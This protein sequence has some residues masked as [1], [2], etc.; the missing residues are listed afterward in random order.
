MKTHYL[1]KWLTAALLALPLPT[2][3]EDIDLFVGIPPSAADAPNVLLVLDNAANF[4]SSAAGSTC[5][6]DGVATLLSGTVGG[7]EQCA[8]YK[9][10]ESLPTTT[11]PDTGADIVL[12]NVGVMAYNS[13]NVVD[14][15]NAPC[16][17]GGVGGC[18]LYPITALTATN[19]A[20]FLAWI[21]TWKTSGGGPGYIKASG[22]ATGAAMQEAWA[23]FSGKTG[24]SGKS[25]AAIK[26]ASTC[27]KN[28]LVFVGN[29]YSSS[30]SPGD[31]APSGNGPANSLT[32]TNP[33]SDKNAN[34]AATTAQKAIITN[35]VNTTCGSFTFPASA[36]E[37]KGFYADEWAR[38]M[39]ASNIVTYTVGILG[40]SCQASYAALLSRMADDDAGGGTYFPTTNYTELVLAF[41]KIFSEIQNKESVFAS[42]SLPVSVNTQGTYLNQVFIGMFRPDGDSLPRWMGN[43]KQF[44][45]GV[46]DNTLKLLDADNNPAINATKGFIAECARSYWTPITDDTYWNFATA[47][48]VGHS[49]SSNTP[50]GNIVEK[51]AQGYKLRS[52]TPADRNVKTCDATCSTT[53]ANFDTSNAGITKAL[54]G[55][56]S[57][58]DADRTLMINW[59]RGLNNKVG[60]EALVAATAMR[61]SS[62]GDVVHSRPIAL[63]YGIAAGDPN[64]V[65]FYGG[66]DGVLRAVNGNRSAPDPKADAN[67]GKELW[68]FIPPESYGSIKR[69]YDNT[70]PI[71]YKGSISAEALPKSYGMDGPITAYKDGDT[72][73][74]YATM[75]RGGRM[76]YAFDVSTPSSPT[77]KWKKGC[78]N[79]LSATQTGF[80]T[81]CTAGFSNI[82]QTWAQPKVVSASGYGGGAS[83]VLIVGGGYDACEDVDSSS[84]ICASTTGNRIYVLDANTGALLKTFDTARSVV[85]DMTVVLD[86]SGMAQYAYTADM[87]GNL[88][89]ITI[90]ADEPAAWG[91]TKIASLGCSTVDTCA[92]N[93]K[94]LYAPDVV[95][96]NGTLVLLVGSGDREKPL[97]SYTN[98]YGVSNYFFMVKDKPTDPTWLS[99]T[100]TGDVICLDSLLSISTSA[101]PTQA[102]VDA[103]KGWYLGMAPHEQVVT[104]SIT[105]FDVVTFSTHQPANPL[106]GECSSTLGT[107]N[108]Y[109]ISYRTAAS[110][111]GTG[112]RFEHVTGDGLPPSPVAGMVTLDDG[113][114]VPFVI[115]SKATSP[116]EGSPPVPFSTVIQPKGRVYWYIQQ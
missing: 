47:N 32:G 101:N 66:N 6:I 112:T 26:P 69:L 76:L 100:C 45:L 38:Y 83:P 8:L 115:G 35:T 49:A 84:P 11:D 79:N 67:A 33:V 75:R 59:A 65:V 99:G 87:G 7:I 70:I 16:Q 48:C 12:L 61:P 80:D 43:L 93:R 62:H 1:K 10:I 13:N 82:G 4:S 39:S 98:A 52:I 24:I 95:D 58:T 102:Q 18:L 31:S 103:T 72:A 23:Y 106:P 71:K 85:A 22:E 51:G 20:T 94:F 2:M 40:P 19:K 44:K 81:G 9:V 113:T 5:I 91:L 27:Y 21:K 25:Y 107:T 116:L 15:L 41:Q 28:Y 63:N 17:D 53:L 89:R 57:M 64:V 114:T 104:S 74:L 36:H 78:P 46:V 86:S 92:S 90:G 110:A 29:S 108:V 30:G 54:L 105:V 34:P 42:V 3:A 96:D 97:K 88:Y 50:D 37:G 111:N 56:A 60:D 77:L 14:H 68:S 73:W 55:N 109:N